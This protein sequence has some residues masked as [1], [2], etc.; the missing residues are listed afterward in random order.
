MNEFETEITIPLVVSVTHYRP[1]TPAYDDCAP[2]PAEVEYNLSL[3]GGFELTDLAGWI[4][5]CKD[6]SDDIHERALAFG[7]QLEMMNDQ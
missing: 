1:E 5:S 6:T 7:R 4:N 2:C 3:G